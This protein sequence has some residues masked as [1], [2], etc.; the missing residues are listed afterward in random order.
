MCM[1]HGCY[2]VRACCCC[3]VMARLLCVHHVSHSPVINWPDFQEPDH[4]L[5]LGC[6]STCTCH[7]EMQLRN[8]VTWAKN[9]EIGCFVIVHSRHCHV[10]TLALWWW[11]W[12]LCSRWTHL[13]VC[14]WSRS[15]L[16]HGVAPAHW[17]VPVLWPFTSLTHE[18]H[19]DSYM[20]STNVCEV[21]DQVLTIF[22]QVALVSI[23][24]LFIR[25]LFRAKN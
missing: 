7:R 16:S 4:A 11:R 12:W 6:A 15:C 19:R 24:A 25:A 8:E 1:V 2:D 10:P 13:L 5:L 14:S 17:G 23:S 9:V 21:L 3:G 20:C 22:Q 18:S